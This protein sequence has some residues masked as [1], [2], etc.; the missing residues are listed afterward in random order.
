M[1]FFKL[2]VLEIR[3]E[4]PNAVS[5]LF[6]VPESLAQNFSF[7]QGQYLTIQ[8]EINGANLRRAYSV[9]VAPHQNELRVAVKK[10]EGGVFSSFIN[11][12]LKVNDILEIMPA[13]GK[14]FTPLMPETPRNYVFFAAGSGITPIF[15]LIQAVLHTEPQSTA[16][17]FYGNKNFENIIFREQL[18][19]LKNKF[20]SRF[21]INHVLSKDSGNNLFSGRINTEKV[22][23][24][25]QKM[26]DPQGIDAY[27]LC[28]PEEM[29]FE[30]KDV[31]VG[32]GVEPSK[33]HFELFGKKKITETTKTQ[34][35][36]STETAQIEVILDG[37]SYSFELKKE[38]ESILDAALM[39][40]SELPYACKAGVCCTCR[41]KITEGTVE[42]R[43][44][45]ALE[46]QE[47][48]DGFVL[49]CQ[50]FPTSAKVCVDFDAK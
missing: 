10:V 24:Y 6:E 46:A 9:C 19:A 37:S 33:I 13:K 14:F 39:L 21:S 34:I 16:L 28:G 50:A 2:R 17:L 38:T 22:L 43:L 32:L 1:E 23:A 4:T 31:L 45:Y 47:V 25:C 8:A 3:P 29:I 35:E 48:A 49:T 42:M 26:F 20:I 12:E 7:T 40:G 11:D 18:E 27:F 30:T 15:S 36:K 5:V 41:A 44:N